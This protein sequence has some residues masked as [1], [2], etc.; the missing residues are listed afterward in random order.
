MANG[1]PERFATRA[2]TSPKLQQ[3]TLY[4]TV[5]YKNCHA[6]HFF[7]KGSHPAKS[8]EPAVGRDA[9]KPPRV[10]A[11]VRV[12]KELCGKD[13]K[14]AEVGVLSPT[15]QLRESPESGRIA[16]LKRKL[17]SVGDTEHESHNSS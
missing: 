4:S 16:R 17:V 11:D 2:G 10:K 8:C 7:R 9:S 1:T 14:F 5:D 3:L 6:W 13:K 15:P 12:A